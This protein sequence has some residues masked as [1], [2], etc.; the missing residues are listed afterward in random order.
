MP[1][2]SGEWRDCACGLSREEMIAR[3]KRITLC[4]REEQEEVEERRGRK[5]REEKEEAERVRT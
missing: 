5:G 3:M 4:D 2:G 1:T